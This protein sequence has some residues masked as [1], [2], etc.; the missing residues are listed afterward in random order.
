MT[1]DST[2]FSPV[3]SVWAAVLSVPVSAVSVTSGVVTEGF[4]GSGLPRCRGW[5]LLLLL[6]AVLLD[7]IARC[8]PDLFVGCPTACDTHAIICARQFEALNLSEE[9]LEVPYR[10]MQF[11]GFKKQQSDC[12]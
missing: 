5:R 4:C 8:L 12:L 7:A 9:S 3:K 1:E 10:R 6:L 2:T 11:F